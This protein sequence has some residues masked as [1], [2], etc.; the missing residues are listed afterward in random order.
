MSAHGCEL[1]YTAGLL[2]DVGRTV[3]PDRAAG[4]DL[5]GVAP[6]REIRQHPALGAKI[7]RDLDVPESVAAAV[8]AHHERVDGRGYP[9]G[10]AGDAIPEL[11]RI[12]AVAEVYDTLTAGDTYRPRM[13]SFQAMVELRRVAGT[14]LETRFVEALADVL[15]GRE[16]EH[17]HAS[18]AQLD[19]EL[20][21]KRRI[22]DA[23][24]P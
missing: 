8:A 7:V 11:A 22:A 12:V 24:T 19:G 6:W 16:L 10:V 15:A 23:L 14:Q 9:D 4:G 18:A 17:R 1:A 21:L 2:H 5:L 20:A 3:L 13:S